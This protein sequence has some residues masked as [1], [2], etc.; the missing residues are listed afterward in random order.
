[1]YRV[2]FKF[3]SRLSVCGMRYKTRPGLTYHY[4]HSH[5]EDDGK[6]DTKSKSSSRSNDQSHAID[7]NS[8]YLTGTARGNTPDWGETVFILYITH[9]SIG[10]SLY[11]PMFLHSCLQI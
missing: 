3:L 10:L 5:K 6:E 11:L 2:C 4:A 1:M 8:D 9:L 7:A